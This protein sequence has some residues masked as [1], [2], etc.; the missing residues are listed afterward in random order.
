MKHF[1]DAENKVFAFD[2]DGSQDH[3]IA[4]DLV[5]VSDKELNLILNPPL[6]I[7][8]IKSQKVQALSD[9]VGSKIKSGFE[10]EALGFAHFYPSKETDQL[11]LA[12]LVAV[13]IDASYVCADQEGRWEKRSHTASQLKQ[14]AIDGAMFKLSLLDEFRMRRDL[15]NDAETVDEVNAISD[16]Y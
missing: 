4:S 2:D 3:L 7:D 14:V 16:V 6:S 1:K 15:V 8:D 5:Q 9:A 13:N 10:S 12:G 11:N